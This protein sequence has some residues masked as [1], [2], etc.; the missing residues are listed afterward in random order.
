MT[1]PAAILPLDGVMVLDLTTTV[2]GPYATQ[3]L[4]DLGADVVKIEAPGGDPVRG[5]GPARSPGMGALFLGMNRNKRSVVLDLREE[6]HKEALWRLVDGADVLVHNMRSGKMDSLGLGPAAVRSR[7]PSLV[8]AS[9]HGYGEA[10]PYANRP[11]YD[12]VIQGEAGFC[13]LFRRR[14]GEPAMI[15]TIAI[16]KAAATLAAG[17]I[18]AAYINRMRTGE[19]VAIEIPMFEAMVGFNMVEH[20]YGAALVP[21]ESGYGYPRILSA[22]R[23]PHRT[24]DGFIC[25]LPYTD[26]QWA[27]FWRLT[28]RPELETDP[29]FSTMAER[30]KHIGAV[31]EQVSAALSQRS[32]AE[33]L[34]LLADN[35]IPAGPANTLEQVRDDPHLEAVGFFRPYEHETEGAMEIPDT[36]YR[37]NG[38]SLPVRHGQPRLG[39]D[40]AEVLLEAG[41]PEEL[42]GR[43]C[44]GNETKG[45]EQ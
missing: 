24:S 30:S 16:D 9:L 19:G 8:Y 38:A 3:I 17:G 41:V 45:V 35:N 20:Q 31:Y 7:N 10:G 5:V 21:P 23:R 13:D 22:F 37:I 44:G 18:L 29:R 40:T 11:A 1:P 4:G 32:T 15:P 39:A 28:D 6:A 43:I 36:P 42:V 14:D 2:F 33:W 25:M 27:S 12:D 26:R 34:A